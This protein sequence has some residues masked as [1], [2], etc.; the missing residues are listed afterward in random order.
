MTLSRRNWLKTVGLGGAALSLPLGLRSAL[1]QSAPTTAP[2]SAFSRFNIGDFEITVIQDGTTQFETA[3]FGANAAEGEVDALLEANNLPT[4][5]ANA[6]FNITLVNTGDQL[7]LLDTGL[8]SGAAPTGGRLIPTLEVLG[9]T[10]ADINAVIVSHFHPDHIN[11]VGDGTS[12][13]FPNAT[14]YFPQ[15]EWDFLQNAPSDLQPAASAISL[16]QPISDNDQLQFYA[17]DA[18]IVP[19]IQAVAAPGHTPGHMALLVASGSSQLLN[20]VDSAVQSVVSLQRPDWFAAFDADGPTASET[21]LALLG[22]AVDEGLQVL[23]YHFPFPGVGYV[24]REGDG[25]RFTASL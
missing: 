5:T 15:P 17:P 10:P 9:V 24:A 16:L 12:A 23:G 6:T 3:I 19:G 11:G 20:L 1:A 25:F 22:R 2:V 18:E 21:R 4:G 14:Y 8:G 13:A 7:V